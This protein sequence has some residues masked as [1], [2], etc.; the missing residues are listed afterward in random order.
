ML[1]IS[2]FLAVFAF[3]Q[4]SLAENINIPFQHVSGQDYLESPVMMIDSLENSTLSLKLKCS[5]S[6]L[7]RLYWITSYDQRFEQSKSVW[8]Y[9][10]S[11]ERAYYFNISSQNPYW[12]GW[13]KRLIIVPE[14]SGQ[15]EVLSATIGQGTLFTLISSGWKEFWGPKGRTPT[16]FSINVTHSSPIFGNSV[17]IYL[18]W[19]IGLAFTLSLILNIIKKKPKTLEAITAPLLKATKTAFLTIIAAWLLLALNADYNYFSLFKD[20][21]QKYFGKTIEQKHAEA[22]GEDY[23]EFLKFAAKTLPK[24]P[25]NFLI[26]SSINSPDL[27]G[28]LFLVPHVLAGDVNKKADYILVFYPTPDQIKQLQGLP[29]FARLDNNKYIVKGKK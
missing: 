27:A 26:Y 24:K 8:F 25:V 18:Y 21:Y 17:N 19:L 22:Y 12:I 28:R 13:I 7:A 6:G 2:V 9:T 3:C 4:P 29:V 15:I 10:K 20:N 11:G 1:T 5:N 14:G 16:G 23:Y